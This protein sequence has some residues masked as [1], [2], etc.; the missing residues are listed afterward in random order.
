MK[1]IQEMGSEQKRLTGLTLVLKYFIYLL[2]ILSDLFFEEQHGVVTGSEVRVGPSGRRLD[3][4]AFPWCEDEGHRGPCLLHRTVEG[5]WD[6]PERAFFRPPGS[7]ADAADITPGEGRW[8]ALDPGK[9]CS[10][11]WLGS[12][13]WRRSG[14]GSPP[15]AASVSQEA[16]NSGVHEATHGGY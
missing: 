7:G 13:P 8:W 15:D 16:P 6:F 12:A 2:N 5:G 10:C 11:A 4:R 1:P 14:P 3:E 9:P